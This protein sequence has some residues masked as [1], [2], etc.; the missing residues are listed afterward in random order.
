[1]T[2]DQAIARLRE[3]NE[4]VPTP[5]RLP[6]EQEVAAAEAAL[7]ETFHPDF[8]TY[9]LNASDIVFGTLEPVT[10]TDADAHTHLETVC[11]GAWDDY[12]VPQDLLPICED[13]GDFYCLDRKGR[14]K[15]WSS[16][17]DTSE[18]WPNLATWIDQV[19]IGES[20]A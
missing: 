14:V 3:L 5:A 15:F 16:D 20:D 12:E 1:M 10:I 19:W 18:S 11:R 2:L 8:R 7:G 13:N 4:P 6:N 9:L 17:G